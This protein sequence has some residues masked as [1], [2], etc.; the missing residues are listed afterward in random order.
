[1]LRI[2]SERHRWLSMVIKRP[3]NLKIWVK[4]KKK[5]LISCSVCVCVC[6][7]SFSSRFAT[8]GSLFKYVAAVR[9]LQ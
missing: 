1:M 4:E 8:A 6:F 5:D 9:S 2:S 7:G 3:V